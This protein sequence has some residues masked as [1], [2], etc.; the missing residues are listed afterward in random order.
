MVVRRGSWLVIV[1]VGRGS[2]FVHVCTSYVVDEE[3]VGK[4]KRTTSRILESQRF[5]LSFCS[6]M[7][8]FHRRQI[9]GTPNTQVGNFTYGMFFAIRATCRCTEVAMNPEYLCDVRSNPAT[10]TT[11][12]STFNNYV[13]RYLS[14]LRLIIPTKS[15]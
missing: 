14:A 7:Q 12:E 1:G 6:K 5:S 15:Y 4:I 2:N 13:Y 8:V 3:S 10:G 9:P 11:R